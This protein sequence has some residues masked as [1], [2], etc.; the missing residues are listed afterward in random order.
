[1]ATRKLG[2]VAVGSIVKLKEN[3]AAVNYLVVQQGKPSSIY[4]DSCNGTWLLRQ[5]CIENRVWY[6]FGSDWPE[7][8]LETSDIQPWLNS[9]MLSKYDS[10]T[11]SWI[12]QVKIPYH[13]G[14]GEDGSDQTG[15]NGLS[16]KVFLLSAIEVGSMLSSTVPNDGWRLNYFIYG[17]N[18]EAN[19]KRIAK[20][21]GV[22]APH[23]GCVL[24]I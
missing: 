22:V 6:D 23:G 15:A 13:K 5:D 18:T 9:T 14:G 19:Q 1:M 10:K 24:L 8:T 17:I 7:N 16:C 4:D 20:L 2:D 21:Y 11:Q 3:G 12:K